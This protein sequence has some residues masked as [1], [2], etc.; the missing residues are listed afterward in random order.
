M[1]I[2]IMK[3]LIFSFLKEGAHYMQEE[4]KIDCI[5]LTPIF[6]ILKKMFIQHNKV[7]F[8]PYFLSQILVLDKCISNLLFLWVMVSQFDTLKTRP[9]IYVTFSLGIQVFSKG[10]CSPKLKVVRQILKYFQKL[11]KTKIHYY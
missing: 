4:N 1:N 10:I 2:F 9:Y 6:G 7:H 5:K 11:K 3:S 8:A